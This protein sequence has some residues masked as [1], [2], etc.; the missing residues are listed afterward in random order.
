MNLDAS[1]AEIINYCSANISLFTEVGKC[2]LLGSKGTAETL[3]GTDRGPSLL[4]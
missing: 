3:K 2:F 1:P 4:V